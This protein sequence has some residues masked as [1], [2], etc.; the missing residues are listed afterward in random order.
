MVQYASMSDRFIS[1]RYL[2]DCYH[3]RQVADQIIRAEPN[4]AEVACDACGATRVFVPRIEDVDEAGLFSR[5]GPWPAWALVHETACRN[6][7]VTGPH[8]IAIS[9]RYI[10]VRCRNCRFTH[11]YKF[12]LEYIAG[13]PATDPSA[14]IVTG[15]SRTCP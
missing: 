10:S 8:D 6:C 1:T 9:C 2:T 7:H 13:D 5:T 11:L 4:R 3:C 12:D 15:H 14:G